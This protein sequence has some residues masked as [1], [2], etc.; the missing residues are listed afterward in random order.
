MFLP[1]PRLKAGPLP[2]RVSLYIS[3]AGK[4]P[5]DYRDKRVKRAQATLEITAKSYLHR[6]MVAAAFLSTHTIM[7][8]HPQGCTLSHVPSFNMDIFSVVE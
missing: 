8:S 6:Q 3:A 5:S 1:G 2:K 7:Y 4:D